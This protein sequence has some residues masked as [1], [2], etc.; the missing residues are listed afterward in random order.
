MDEI[1]RLIAAHLAGLDDDGKIEALN[2]IKRFMTEHSPLGE[3]P[4]D[5]VVW[6]QIEKVHANDYNPN[7]V[8]PPEMA[9]LETSI[10]ADGYTQ[11]VVTWPDNDGFE[12]VDGFHRSTAP[13]RNT[14][15]AAATKGYLPVVVIRSQRSEKAD[16]MASTI[17]HNRARGK[18][19]VPSMTEIV[20]YLTKRNWTPQKIARELGMEP[21][22]VLRFQQV[23]GLAE[24]YADREFS[25][26]WEVE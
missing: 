17:R 15:I 7:T 10:E 3:H 9:L 16:R 21:D 2:D 14:I 18:H 23:G 22:E 24:L 20:N 26:A 11:P 25:E 4:V 12:V 1:K 5:C 8:A 19:G 13:R 6:E